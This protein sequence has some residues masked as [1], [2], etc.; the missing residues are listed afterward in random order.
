ME[1][2]N[3]LLVH[4]FMK[5]SQFRKYSQKYNISTVDIKH[6]FV[7]ISFL[8]VNAYTYYKYTGFL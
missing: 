4:E 6:G 8:I 7:F 2:G 3:H 5:Q 1:V